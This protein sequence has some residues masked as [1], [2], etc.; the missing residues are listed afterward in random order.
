MPQSAGII[1]LQM[2]YRVSLGE[3]LLPSL[4]LRIICL[5]W[6]R[7]RASRS[8]VMEGEWGE[9]RLTISHMVLPAVGRSPGEG[10]EGENMHTHLSCVHSRPPWT[11][12]SLSAV[13]SKWS[14][15]KWLSQEG[16]IWPK[17]LGFQDQPIIAGFHGASFRQSMVTL[18]RWWRKCITVVSTKL[19]WV[20]FRGRKAQRFS[21]AELG[22]GLQTKKDWRNKNFQGTVR[23]KIN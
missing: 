19:N 7:F 17:D 9:R 14:I 10:L 23:K 3:L 13:V 21:E 8:Y 6:K 4:Y 16:D 11:E 2:E 20:K 1:Q 5:D 22:N 15:C 18:L 12:K